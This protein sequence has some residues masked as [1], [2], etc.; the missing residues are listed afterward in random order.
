MTTCPICSSAKLEQ[1]AFC[2]QC[3]WTLPSEVRT[4][5][6]HAFGEEYEQAIERAKQWLLGERERIREACK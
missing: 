5:L 3:F 2:R 6:Y 1:H 4:F